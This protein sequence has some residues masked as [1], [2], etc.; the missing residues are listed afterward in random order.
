M[1]CVLQND[2]DRF[3]R[4][5]EDEEDTFHETVNDYMNERDDYGKTPLDMSAILGRVEMLKELVTRGAE[6]NK[7]TSSGEIAILLLSKYDSF[8]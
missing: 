6:V 4:C 8:A 3:N 7:T 5:F 2:V 1:K